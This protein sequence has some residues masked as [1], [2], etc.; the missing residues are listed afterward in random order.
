[1][2]ASS[3]S[4]HHHPSLSR[5]IVVAATTFE[6]SYP[7]S[8]SRLS[9]DMRFVALGLRHPVVEAGGGSEHVWQPWM[10]PTG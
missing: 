8:S 1:M 6:A 3:G 9:F 5:M 4:D 2:H 7:N 10:S